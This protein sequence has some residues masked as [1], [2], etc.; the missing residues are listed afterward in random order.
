MFIDIS[1]NP[2]TVVSIIGTSDFELLHMMS[3]WMPQNCGKF[4]QS[5]VNIQLG[6]ELIKT[7]S[8]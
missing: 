3:G 8:P 7:L 2:L 1:D 6:L 5:V 4:P